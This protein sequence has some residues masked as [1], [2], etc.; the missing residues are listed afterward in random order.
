MF[1]GRAR[2]ILMRWHPRY[3]IGESVVIADRLEYVDAYLTT[4]RA[5]CLFII[6]SRSRFFADGWARG[7]GVSAL[8]TIFGINNKTNAI[9]EYNK[10]PR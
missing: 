3:S 2:R 9:R 7:W 6:F 1:I 10:S 5:P 4:T 8:I